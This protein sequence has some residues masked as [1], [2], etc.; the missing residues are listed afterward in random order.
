MTEP[1]MPLPSRWPAT[2]ALFGSLAT[3]ICCALPALLVSVGLGAVMAGLYAAVPQ[4]S[5]I[6]QYKEAIF[7]GAGLLLAGAGVMHW[8]ARNAPCP[9]DPAQAAACTRVRRV[10][11]VVLGVAV[12]LYSF[13][14]FMAFLAPRLLL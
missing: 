7:L 6:G 10:S 1:V 3:L 4:A 11:A 8:R 5:L 14:A 2:L 13:G 12:V 9:A